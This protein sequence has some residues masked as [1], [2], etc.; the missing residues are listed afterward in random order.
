MKLPG[1]D[2]IQV[3]VVSDVLVANTL[4]DF[5]WL[6]RDA[7]PLETDSD[8]W[9]LSGPLHS[10]VLVKDKDEAEAPNCE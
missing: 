5:G 10:V 2:Y 6:T 4:I 1:G 8:G 7:E 3:L 9:N